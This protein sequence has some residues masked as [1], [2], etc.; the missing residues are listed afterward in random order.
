MLD[1]D[2]AAT[3]KPYRAAPQRR[4]L[5]ETERSP[6]PLLAPVPAERCQRAEAQ[7]ELLV[8]RCPGV[9][10]LEPRVERCQRAEA[11][12]ELPVQRS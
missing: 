7:S 3:T 2:C 8:E 10:Q 5:A 9:A 1:L 11:Q 6:A 4:G 12:P